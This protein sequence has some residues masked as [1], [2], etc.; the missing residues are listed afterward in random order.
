MLPPQFLNRLFWWNNPILMKRLKNWIISAASR[1][2]AG[3]VLAFQVLR[4]AITRFGTSQ[5]A[6]AAASLGYYAFFSM[7]PLLIFLVSAGSFFLQGEQVYNGVIKFISE[8]F[9]IS[10]DWLEN[11]IQNI[12]SLRGSVSLIGL[13]SLLWSSSSFFTVL[14][15]N[16]NRAWPSASKRTFVQDRLVGLTMVAVIVILL[17]LSLLTSA[18]SQLLPLW[19]E[20]LP[21]HGVVDGIPIWVRLTRLIPWLLSYLMFTNLYRWVPTSKVC[22][23]GALWGA[24]AATIGWQLITYGFTMYLKSGI[25]RYELIYGSLGALASLLFW[26]YLS[27]MI[28][29]FGAHLASSVQEKCG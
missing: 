17:I 3:F 26:F 11:N 5:A 19:L 10:V 8:I 27:G 29:I 22:W 2:R 12:L 13:I 16:I 1:T 25:I 21:N 7:F 14:A 28:A 15:R 23:K 20:S 6:E 18:I 24:G 4:E 9:P